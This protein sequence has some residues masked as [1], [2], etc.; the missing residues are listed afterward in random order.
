MI[1]SSTAEKEAVEVE[2]IDQQS[3]DIWSSPR[4]EIDQYGVPTGAQIVECTD[5]GIE[6]TTGLTEFCSHR[7][8]CQYE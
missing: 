6:T 2:E 8:D 4:P 3:A 5:C 7:E 1:E